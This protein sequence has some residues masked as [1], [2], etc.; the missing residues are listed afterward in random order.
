VAAFLDRYYVEYVQAEQL[1]SAGTIQGQL[2]AIKACLGSMPVVVLERP[3]DILRFKA[4]YRLG[5]TIATVNRALGTL[6]SAINWGR[7][8]DPPLLTTTP[9]HRFGISVKTK[10]ETKRDRRV[11][12]E[13]EH[14]LLRAC[15]AMNSAGHSG[16]VTRCTI[17]SLGHSK[18]AAGKVRC[19]AF[20]T[21]T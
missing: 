13:E 5:R 17:G 14:A 20:R 15:A 2:K 18:L 4:H 1:R 19:C 7:F 8:Q 10:E 16:S 9:F 11:H 6:R 3:G 21:A 12:G